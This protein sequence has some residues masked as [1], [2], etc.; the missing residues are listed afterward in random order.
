MPHKVN[1]IDFE[2]AEGNLGIANSLFVFFSSKLS[3]SRLQ[4]DLT[5][6]TVLRNIGVAFAH[7][8]IAYRSILKGLTKIE[9]DKNAMELAL[10]ENV[11]VISE[12][13]QNVL[14]SEKIEKPYELLKDLTRGKKKSL[15]D[16]HDFIKSID[17]NKKIKEKLL[18]ITPLNYTGLASKIVEEFQAKIY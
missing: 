5:D 16:I 12:A 6:S 7:S 11:E 18:K 10:L 8:L 14:R 9:V 4:R 2:N 15:E 3:I 13:I 1:P 17:I